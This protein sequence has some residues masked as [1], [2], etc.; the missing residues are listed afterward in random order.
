MTV[1]YEWDCE[2]VADGESED[3][4]DGEV[5]DHFHAETYREVAARAATT[6]EP[7]CRHAIVLVRDD[8]DR[9][10]WA[11]LEDGALP[12]EFTDA[13]G[14]DYARVPKRFHAEVARN[15]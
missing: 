10:A 12:S 4:E 5:L 3:H 1:I 6:P 7:G 9:R 14:T 13:D 8:D 2:T 15:A 11:Y